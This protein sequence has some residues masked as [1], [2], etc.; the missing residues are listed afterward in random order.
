MT[1]RSDIV[2][3]IQASNLKYGLVYTK[4][5]GWVDLGHANPV[6]GA[7]ELWDQIKN[8]KGD[9]PA[10][11][12]KAAKAGYYRI[13]YSQGFGKPY[14]KIK[15]GKTFDIK[16]GLNI[17]EKKSV[18]L[19]IFLDISEHFETIQGNWFWG[20]LTDSSFSAEDLV[21]NL[22]GF[23]R[24]IEPEKPFLQ[25]CEPVSK[26]EALRIWDTYGAVGSNKNYRT[27]P[28]IY[29]LDESKNHGPMSSSLPPAFNTIQPAK[30][31]TLF[32]QVK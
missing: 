12:G 22:I 2:D 30:P 15:F 17:E 10:K 6:G 26:K 16:K 7:S 24:A 8:E 21:S 9:L 19:A 29:P 4:K 1:K 32:Y 25:I 20:K 11:A 31:G 18:A 28:Y 3:G 14:F 13:H 5:C 27:T 23:Y